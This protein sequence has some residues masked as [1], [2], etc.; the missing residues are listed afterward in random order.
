RSLQNGMKFG[1]GVNVPFGLATKYNKDWV[2]RYHAV[3]SHLQALN[4][5]P[6]IAKQFN[7][8][9]AVGFGL[10][11]QRIDVKLSSAIDLTSLCEFAV[12]GGPYPDGFAD[13]TGDSIGYGWNAGLTYEIS[14]ET[15]M[16]LAYRSKVSQDVDGNADFTIPSPLDAGLA[17]LF[18]DTGLKSSVDLPATLSASVQHR[19]SPSISLVAD[20]TWTGWSN[21]Q[22]LRIDYDNPVQDDTV[23]TQAW[24]DSLR[25]AMG[26]NYRLNNQWLL[27]TGFAYDESPIPDDE[28]RTAR[29]PGN[30]R[31]WLAFGFSYEG[32]NNITVDVGYTHLFI[33]DATVN[34]TLEIE[35]NSG[36]G[37]STMDATLSGTF[38]DSADT[39]SGQV[40]WKY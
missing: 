1:V 10:N 20:V 21:F 2:G 7:D 22:E 32:A 19:M 23:T 27:R 13:L 24:E 25:I 11:V 39:I 14:P 9:L 8:K 34:N 33:S 36:L 38:E 18:T 37:V 29:I 12:C 5:N 35:E 31:R 26:A 15:R 6:S 17:P 3:E 16:G 4:I 40:V 30:D 28:H